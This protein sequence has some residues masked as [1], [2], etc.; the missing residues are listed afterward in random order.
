[1]DSPDTTAVICNR[2]HRPATEEELTTARAEPEQWRCEACT[3]ME[4]A[5]AD[6]TL[7]NHVFFGV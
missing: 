2:C 5:L 4:V 6:A 3:R 1:M 7:R